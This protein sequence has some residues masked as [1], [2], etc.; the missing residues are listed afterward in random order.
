MWLH[1]VASVVIAR[2]KAINKQWDIKDARAKAVLQHLGEM[3][4]L[5]YQPMSIVEDVRFRRCE[6]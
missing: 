2:Y 6:I 5:D 3:I 4:A 1:R